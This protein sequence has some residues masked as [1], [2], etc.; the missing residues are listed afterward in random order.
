MGAD[1]FFP[2]LLSVYFSPLGL[3]LNR[4]TNKQTEF[5]ST[6]A[7]FWSVSFSWLCVVLSQE[8]ESPTSDICV[9]STKKTLQQTQVA[10]P[11]IERRV[12]VEALWA[13]HDYW[14]FLWHFFFHYWHKL[15]SKLIVM[16]LC[17]TLA[18]TDHD[19]AVSVKYS[20]SFF[21]RT[22]SNVWVLFS[23]GEVSAGLKW[24]TVVRLKLSKTLILGGF[25]VTGSPV[26]MF[27]H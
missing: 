11:Q 21:K 18:E 7:A 20:G 24:V 27:S 10:G 22:W 17:R 5:F 8:D 14:T 26:E 9:H 1:C 19:P 3:N 15:R 13:K 23:A 6:E 12:V 16:C 4:N 2:Q 25:L